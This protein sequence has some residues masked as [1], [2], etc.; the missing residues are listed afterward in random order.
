[1]IIA[2]S[3]HSRARFKIEPPAANQGRFH[4]R[5][6]GLS[7]HGAHGVS[8]PMRFPRFSVC[9]SLTNQSVRCLMREIESKINGIHEKMLAFMGEGLYIKMFSCPTSVADKT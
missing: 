8:L 9:S 1:M 7:R 5:K 6:F 3:K 2:Y 4:H